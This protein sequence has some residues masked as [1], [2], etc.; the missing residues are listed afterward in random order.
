MAFPDDILTQDEEVVL[1]VHP[2]WVSLVVPVL[3]TVAALVF[4]VLGVF[5][6]PGGVTQ[7]PIQYLVLVI[8][9]GAIGYLTIRPWFRWLT[10]HYVVTTQRLVIREGIL[11]RTGRDVPLA[12][13]VGVTVRQNIIERL[14]DSGELV[15]E[16]AG[17][18][19]RMVLSYMPHAYRVEET[20]AD[21]AAPYRAPGY[22][23][24]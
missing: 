10:T 12:W 23:G 20:I 18:P 13:L 22:P 11:T 17:Q 8:A 4:A 2:H 6:A 1:H 21:L 15:I 3:W 5:F 7:R 9:F 24:S 14:L 19:G 16:N